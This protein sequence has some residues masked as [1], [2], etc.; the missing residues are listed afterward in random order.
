[1]VKTLRPLLLAAGAALLLWPA[2]RLAAETPPQPQPQPQSQPPG[3]ARLAEGPDY[4]QCMLALR[5]DPQ[6]AAAFA[7][8]WE[9]TG[10]GEGAEHCAALA[11]LGLGE[12]EK[13]GEQ[14]ERLARRSA[15]PAP[16]RAA[17]LAQAAQAWLMAGQPDRAF[18][19]TTLAL[20]LSPDD[21]DMLVD[22]AVASGNLRHFREAI[23]DL[24]RALALNAGRADALVFR[25]A[26]W[27]HLDQT[28]RAERDVA[29]ALEIE[30]DNAEALLE[31]GILRQLRGDLAGARADWQRTM[32]L[33]P[34]TATADLAQ[35]NLALNE[36]GPRRR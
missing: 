25:A 5:T 17:V 6:G 9:A 4:E 26:A 32:A 14:L 21:V 2:A 15:A 23:E 27:R 13:A 8:A 3:P 24:D 19:A 16:A 33:A 36:V 7:E 12:S 1:L 20:S 22:R 28:E 31:R 18:A 35:Q 29:R 10:G 34:N 11:L 30:P